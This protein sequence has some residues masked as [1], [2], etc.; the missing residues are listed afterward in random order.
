M[1]YD[2]PPPAAA[3]APAKPEV[4]TPLPKKIKDSKQATRKDYVITAVLLAVLIWEV[5]LYDATVNYIT[6]YIDSQKPKTM[7]Q[8]F[9]IMTPFGD[10]YMSAENGDFQMTFLNS[11]TDEAVVTQAALLN[12]DG[13]KCQVTSKL[14]VKLAVG[15]RFNLT[16]TG[17]SKG[18]ASYG[19]T[20]RIGAIINGTTS[21]RSK[22]MSD[23]RMMFPFPTENI[24]ED[25][26][27]QMKEQRT[28]QL[29][30]ME[31]L[32]N[33]SPF[34]SSGPIYGIYS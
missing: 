15:D 32:D 1:P 12:L 29:N 26:L 21:L 5:G 4:P 9:N 17:C 8:D 22:L 3:P 11:G 23:T 18:G 20:F 34:T 7:T 14:P 6:D 31:G 16:G 33:P 25:Q 24:P 27:K 28:E 2:A 30:R 10:A 13:G 19:K